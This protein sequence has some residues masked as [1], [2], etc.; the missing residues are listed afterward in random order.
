MNK[1]L[2]SLIKIAWIILGVCAVMF[3]AV[4]VTVYATAKPK[5][6]TELLEQDGLWLDI[7][8]LYETAGDL[9]VYPYVTKV[10]SCGIDADN[11][12]IVNSMSYDRYQI[13]FGVVTDDSSEHNY[14]VEIFVYSNAADKS[15]VKRVWN[16]SVEYDGDVTVTQ[17]RQSSYIDLCGFI[18]D[19]KR[20]DDLNDYVFCKTFIRITAKSG[21]N[22][23]VFKN[24]MVVDGE[25]YEFK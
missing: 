9:E 1:K 13:P 18:G 12:K 2:I 25:V 23:I 8:T 19:I 22:D 10:Y 15:A 6:V 3:F 24:V 16:M 17:N 14:T 20:E 11:V 4:A 21:F 5:N 7:N